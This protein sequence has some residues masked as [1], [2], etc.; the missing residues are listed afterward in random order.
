MAMIPQRLDHIR[1]ATLAAKWCAILAVLFL[2]ILFVGLAFG[3]TSATSPRF[4]YGLAT[5]AAM[6]AIASGLSLLWSIVRVIIK[7]EATT[8]R[9]YDVMR[10]LNASIETHEDSLKTLADN[11]QLSD[12]AKAIT[13]REKERTALRLAINEEIIRGDWEAAYALVELLEERH[14]YKN[15]AMRLRQEVDMSRDRLRIDA[16]HE[17]VQQVRTWLAAQHWDR[18]RREMDRLLAEYPNDDQV[19][20]LPSE[21]HKARGDQKRRLLK[22]WDEAVQR[23]EVDRGIEILKELDQYLTPSEAAALEE[24]ARDVFKA[25]LSNMGVQFSLAVA[26]QNWSEAL[27]VGEQIMRE[28][29]NSRMAKEVHERFHILRQRAE[30]AGIMAPSAANPATSL[31][32]TQPHV[33]MDGA[34]SAAEDVC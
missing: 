17:A 19:A 32:E 12:A 15:E 33:P 5:I 22:L 28:F 13:H 34:S 29:P 2:A 16:L 23:N 4:V 9:M 20:R 1:R 26:D 24:S 6:L 31:I 3:K 27:S 7:L 18:A 11:V 21:F 8:H 10:D 14:G 30:Q 25:K